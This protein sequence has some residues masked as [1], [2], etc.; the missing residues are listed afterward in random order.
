VEL[1]RIVSRAGPSVR[2]VIGGSDIHPD[3]ADALSTFPVGTYFVFGEG[4]A[5]FT[6]LLYLFSIAREEPLLKGTARNTE[7]GLRIH[8]EKPDLLAAEAIPSPI[9]DGVLKY[10]HM[11]WFPAFP[12]V[13]GCPY[14]CSYCRWGDGGAVRVFPIAR[15]LKELQALSKAPLDHIW[16]TDPIFGCDVSRDLHLIEA[17]RQWPRPAQFSFELHPKHISPAICQALAQLPLR[18]LAVGVQ[19]VSPT[20]LRR[21]GRDPSAENAL[22]SLQMLYSALPDPSVIHID[23]ILGLPGDDPE[24]ALVSLDFLKRRFPKACFYLSLL[25]VLP[26]ARIWPESKSESWL[27]QQARYDYELIARE[28]L[29]LDHTT[30]LKRIILGVDFLQH[31]QNRAWANRAWM[32]AEVGFSVLAYNTGT[33]L[34]RK[35]LHRH[36]T[37]NRQFYFDRTF[38]SSPGLLTHLRDEIELSLGQA[39]M[40]LAEVTRFSK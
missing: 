21:C 37:Y 6:E 34:A 5:T 13:R 29:D 26:G 36:Q 18:W 2:L 30:L 1:C 24:R 33:V 40:H 15:I 8:P 35:N 19:S 22:E 23:L 3:N 12:S 32:H 31:P 11:S 4:E 28:G 10:D 38:E 27:C 20:A 17:L 9:L 25:H 14:S 7:H 16:I 39:H